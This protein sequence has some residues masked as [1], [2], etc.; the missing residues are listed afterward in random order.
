[1]GRVVTGRDRRFHP[2]KSPPGRANLFRE[3]G[4]E[5][6]ALRAMVARG[7]GKGAHWLCLLTTSARGPPRAHGRVRRV[8]R[9]HVAP[10]GASRGPTTSV[11]T[12]WRD[13]P[14]RA[15]S[16]RASLRDMQPKQAPYDAR[17]ATCER[18][19]PVAQYRG[20][21]LHNGREAAPGVVGCALRPPGML[22]PVPS[23]TL[24]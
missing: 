23:D 2:R 24:Q 20:S 17:S 8:F 5:A 9:A 21:R 4:R 19:A 12:V 1:M 10:R 13:F 6:G 11:P 22:F 7:D 3:A 18:S 14:E 16:V 15:A